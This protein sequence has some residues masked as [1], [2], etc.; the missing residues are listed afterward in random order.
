MIRTYDEMRQKVAN[1]IQKMTQELQ[2]VLRP[3]RAAKWRDGY[4]SGSKVDLKRMIQR[5]ARN[6]GDLDFWQRK[7]QVSKRSVA[8]TLL[9]DLSG[10]M[11]GIKSESALQGAIL[12]WESLQSLGI[13]ASISGF[14]TERIP[15]LRFGDPMVQE[16]RKKIANMLNLVGSVNHDAEALNSAF[17]ELIRQPVDEHVLIVISDGQPVGPNADA[18]LHQVVSRI[19]SRVH[20][21]GLGLGTDT[22]HVEQYYPHARGGIPIPDLSKEIGWSYKTF[23]DADDCSLH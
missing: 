4:T 6:Q 15:I 3:T 21:I 11:H 23:C 14:K 13:A 22:Q 2:N 17:E 8:A 5:E 7:T 19:K 9:I 10:S 20:L 18:E 1:Q 16:N 12:F